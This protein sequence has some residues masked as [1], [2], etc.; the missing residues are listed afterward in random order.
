MS[1]VSLA[2][3]GII[4]TNKLSALNDPISACSTTGLAQQQMSGSFYPNTPNS[5]QCQYFV[6]GYCSNNW[7]PTCEYVSNDQTPVLPAM[8]SESGNVGDSNGVIGVG[9][10]NLTLGQIHIRQTA[11]EKYRK[12]MSS[13]CQRRYE[14]FDPTVANSPMISKWISSGGS[15]VAIYDVDEKTIDADP[16]MNKILNNP[17]IAMN[18]LI[19]IYNYR[20]ANNTISD[21][22]KTKLYTL[23]QSDWFQQRVA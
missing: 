2:S 8:R 20:K 18:V 21:L 15:C 5:E 19:P 7:S 13:N 17:T 6:S 9:T 10:P 11:M 3:L 14:P 4:E 12:F 1:Y 16:V 23:F 22:R